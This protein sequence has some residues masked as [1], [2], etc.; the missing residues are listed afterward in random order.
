[1]TKKSAHF[2]S[3]FMFLMLSKLAYAQQIQPLFKN[4]TFA[5]YDCYGPGDKGVVRI[6][7]LK[8]IGP[9]GVLH[10]HYYHGADTTYKLPEALISRLNKIFN[11]EKQLENH[12]LTDKVPGMYYGPLL[13]ISYTTNKDTSDNFVVV[14]GYCDKALNDVIGDLIRLP[15]PKLKGRGGAYQNELLESEIRKLHMACKYITKNDDH[16]PIVKITN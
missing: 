7:T 1:M 14:D 5:I 15:A 2:F 13:F 12:R 4:L 9:N 11:G 10:Y 6:E 16:P 8:E 3:L